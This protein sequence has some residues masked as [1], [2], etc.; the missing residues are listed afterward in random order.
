MGDLQFDALL[1]LAILKLL[2]IYILH[3]WTEEYSRIYGRGFLEPIFMKL[4][5]YIMATV[6]ISTACFINP[7][8]HSVYVC[9]YIPCFT[10]RQ[11]LGKHVPAPA[12][13]RN[14]RRIVERVCLWACLCISLSLLGDNSVRTFLRQRRVVEGVVIYAV[15]K[16][17]LKRWVTVLLPESSPAFSFGSQ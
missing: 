14:N 4:G 7:S 8:H 17:A 1:V 13:S 6:P 9:M 12:N 3:F 10:A 15:L 5:M 2:R 16:W 11:R